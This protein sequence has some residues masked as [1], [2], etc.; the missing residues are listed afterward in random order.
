[1]NRFARMVVLAA[2]FCSAGT[3]MAA[4]ATAAAAPQVIKVW[5]GVAPGAEDWKQKETES[6]LFGGQR[7][8]RN[9]VSPSMEVYLPAQGKANGSGV[10]VAPGGAFRFLSIDGEGIEVARWL[11]S[12]GFAAFLLRYRL[13]ETAESD[14]MFY[15]QMMSALPPLFKDAAALKADMTKYGPPGIADGRQALKLVRS[16][17][18][19]WS[20]KP[21]RIGIMGF[22]AGGTVATGAATDY[23]AASRPDFFVAVY[24]GTWS[25]AKVPADAPPLFI[26]A[27]DDDFITAHGAKPL[28]AAWKAAGKPVEAHYYPTGGHGFG[29][30]KQGKPSDVWSDQLLA[31]LDSLGLL[32]PAK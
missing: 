22:S 10:I 26:A 15:G 21:N 8:I 24:P 12:Q 17:A 20:L 4:D 9:V 25:I 30:K 31:W 14:M 23:D 1:M 16:R 19:E 11:A 18:A 32:K 13:V 6:K 27:T 7:V 5:P 2:G 3:A 29:M 28:E